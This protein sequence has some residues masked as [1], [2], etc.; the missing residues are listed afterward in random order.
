MIEGKQNW[1]KSKM[2]NIYRPY[3]RVK[4]KGV[5]VK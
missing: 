3:R 5:V 4:T 1:N 2:T